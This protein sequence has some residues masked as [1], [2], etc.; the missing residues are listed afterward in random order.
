MTR[1][2]AIKKKCLECGGSNKEVTLC[3]IFDCTLWEY[4]TG[5]HISS[6]AYKRRMTTARKNYKSELS[7]LERV[8]IDVSRL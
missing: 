2:K 1:A 4:R 7:E 8:G 3:H 6:E 5:G